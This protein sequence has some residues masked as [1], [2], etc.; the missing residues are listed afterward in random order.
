MG[1]TGAGAPPEAERGVVANFVTP[2]WF[3]AYGIPLVEGRDISASDTSGSPPVLVVNGAFVRRFFPGRGAIG[4]AVSHSDRPD[5]SRTSTIVGVVGDA[6][7]RTGRMIPGAASLALREPVPPMIY[8]PL[9][10]S[11]GMEPPG[12]TGFAIS[13]RAAAGSPAALSRNVAAAL[14]AVD[15]NLAVTFRPLDDFVHD[16]LG[17]ERLVALLSGFFGALALLLAGLGLY[18]LTSYA[19]SLRR[20]EIGIRLALGAQ[21]GG[22]VGLVLTRVAVLVGLGVVAGTALSVWASRFVATLLYDLAPGD[23]STLAGAVVVLAAV[24]AAA[25][26][27]PAWRAARTDPAT[28]L[29]AH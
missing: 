22:V 16:A 20:I 2:G 7:F 3:R 5:G 26:C 27:V 9:D 24:G 15:P 6:A 17:Q 13:V 29:R 4:G 23:P 19:V 8:V 25:G 11:A 10:Q 21:R 1:V 18:G 14:A 28:V 12:S